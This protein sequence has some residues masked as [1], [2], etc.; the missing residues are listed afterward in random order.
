MSVGETHGVESLVERLE[1]PEGLW[2]STRE[3]YRRCPATARSG[4]R[5]LCGVSFDGEQRM[6][7]RTV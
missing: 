4:Y 6:F 2:R 1:S 5:L 3:T 7:L